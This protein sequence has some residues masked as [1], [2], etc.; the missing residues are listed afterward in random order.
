MKKL[1]LMSL[2][3]SALVCTII[4]MAPSEN[5]GTVKPSTQ[6]ATLDKSP[7]MQAQRA[8]LI[9]K[10]KSQGVFQKHGVPGNTPR[11][12]VKPAFYELDF[13]AKQKFVSVVYAFYFDGSNSGDMVIVYDSRSNKPIGTYSNAGLRLD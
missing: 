12:W 1:V 9:E 8:E 3:V 5:A 7:A 13:D 4:I 6:V 2:V 11:V 10:L